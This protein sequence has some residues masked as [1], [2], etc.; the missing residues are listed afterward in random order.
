MSALKVNLIT[1]AGRTEP[2]KTNSATQVESLI[3]HIHNFS[4]EE[5]TLKK[6]SEIQK[7]IPAP[8][9]KSHRYL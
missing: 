7:Q 3:K 5:F 2:F 8:K 4:S 1:P 9:C 6:C